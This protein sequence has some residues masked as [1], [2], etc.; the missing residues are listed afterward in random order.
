MLLYVK[1]YNCFPMFLLKHL[2]QKASSFNQTILEE[3][4]EKFRD[5]AFTVLS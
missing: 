2:E 5:D 4:D 3:S 1:S